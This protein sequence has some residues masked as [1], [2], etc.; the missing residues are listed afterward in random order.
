MARPIIVDCDNALGVPL[1]DVDDGLALLFLLAQST[2]HVLGVTT[3]YGNAPLSAVTR[4]TRRLLDQVG[5]S[6]PS[7]LPGAPRLGGG[8]TA[9]AR[10]LVDATAARPGEVTIVAIGPLSNLTAAADLDDG[11]FGRCAEVVCIGGTLGPARLGHW[12][13]REVNF[14]ADAVAARRVLSTRDCRVTV[15]PATSCLALTLGRSDLPALPPAIRGAVRRWLTCCRVWRGLRQAVL[16]DLLPALWATRPELLLATDAMVTL[17]FH[18]QLSATP[19]GPHR[20]VRGLCDP[21]A[22]KA[23]ILDRLGTMLSRV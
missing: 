14:E 2:L 8:T 1:C 22:A 6:A 18:G 5:G 13:L 9:A 10:F 12:R 11:F 21:P 7:L 19:G 17:G 4:A 16:W 3:T 23:L 20:L 15:I